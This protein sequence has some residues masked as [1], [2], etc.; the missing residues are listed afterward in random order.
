HGT[1]MLWIPDWEVYENLT[2]VS[3]LSL[4]VVTQAAA[5]EWAT[6]SFTFRSQ[7]S[8]FA[9]I[10]EMNLQKYRGLIFGNFD[11]GLLLSYLKENNVKVITTHRHSPLVDVPRTDDDYKQGFTL[12]AE[13]IKLRE[14]KKPFL[15]A[16]RANDPTYE[17]ALDILVEVFSNHGIE[18][19]KSKIIHLPHGDFFSN[20]T[21]L[22]LEGIHEEI[23]ASDFL[24]TFTP[25][26]LQQLVKWFES[27]QINLKVA[28]TLG[29]FSIL[30][31]PLTEADIVLESNILEHGKQAANMLRVWNLSGKTPKNSTIAM[32]LKVSS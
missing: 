7:K 1:V 31:I 6:K 16:M 27:K 19:P 32:K 4:G 9:R 3:Q 5:Y 2:F 11:H 29:T 22:I 28:T 23:M 18:L 17:P 30:S 14:I 8:L 12:L 25:N 21:N 24:F 26:T 20:E 13:E 10:K 15:I